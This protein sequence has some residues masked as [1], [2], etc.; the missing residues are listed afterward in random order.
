MKKL[1]ILVVDDNEDFAESMADVLGLDD[2][3][4]HTAYSGEEAEEKVKDQDYDVI[5]MDVKLPGRNGVEVFQDIS[6]ANNRVRIIMMTGYSVETLLDQAVQNGAWDVLYKPIDM[7]HVL[8]MLQKIKP[9]GILIADDDPDFIGGIRRI[10]VNNGYRVFTAT[11]GE[12]AIDRIEINNIDVL[13]LDLRM[14]VLN[15]LVTY[16]ELQKKGRSIPTIIV[17]AYAKEEATA[18]TELESMSVTGILRKPFDPEELLNA[19]DTLN[20]NGE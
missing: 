9:G 5:F 20:M 10:L 11:D 13:I 3:E 6:K 4:V 18:L 17:T 14:P 15:G 7:E 2:H 8:D 16:M 19:I 1:K 12:E